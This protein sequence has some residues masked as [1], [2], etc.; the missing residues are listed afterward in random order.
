MFPGSLYNSGLGSPKRLHSTDGWIYR[1]PP[2][3]K[4]TNAFCGLGFTNQFGTN[5]T[6]GD[7]NSVLLVLQN[8]L[9]QALSLLS[10]FNGNFSTGTGTSTGTAG[11]ASNLGQNLSSSA[12]ANLGA[13]AGANLG[14]N[15][16]AGPAS[17]FTQPTQ[18]PVP[19]TALAA[20][21]ANLT[22]GVTGS[23]SLAALIICPAMEQAL[24][25]APQSSF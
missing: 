16:A 14:Q 20:Q 24:Q 22:N 5:F 2:C 6:A 9:Q 13:N 18:P 8:D 1:H 21:G 12:G 15:L 4:L 11:G 25:L 23:T 17:V 19:P 10:G 7:L 3:W